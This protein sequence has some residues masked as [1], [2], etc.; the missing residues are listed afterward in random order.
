[1]EEGVASKIFHPHLGWL[2]VQVTRDDFRD[3]K[4]DK[5]FRMNREGKKEKHNCFIPL[6]KI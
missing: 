4:G 6:T 2:L 5:R 3:F 1:M